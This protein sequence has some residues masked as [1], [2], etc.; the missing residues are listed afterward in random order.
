MDGASSAVSDHLDRQEVCRGI[1]DEKND[2]QTSQRDI[3]RLHV[4]ASMASMSFNRRTTQHERYRGGSIGVIPAVTIVSTHLARFEARQRSRK[5]PPKI[6][7][8]ITD[9]EASA[10]KLSRKGGQSHKMTKYCSAR[11]PFPSLTR[12]SAFS[13][14]NFCTWRRRAPKSL[15]LSA[16]LSRLFS[17]SDW[18]TRDR[19]TDSKWPV[20]SV[21]HDVGWLRCRFASVFGVSLLGRLDNRH[22]TDPSSRLFSLSCSK[23]SSHG[24]CRFAGTSSSSSGG[25]L[26]PFSEA[27]HFTIEDENAKEDW[28]WVLTFRAYTFIRR[29]RIGR[30]SNFDGLFGSIICG[31]WGEG[32]AAGKSGLCRANFE[33]SSF[34]TNF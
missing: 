17:D 4:F 12:G 11:M 8:S 29:R 19:R 34:L 3:K 31:R 28:W 33:F 10:K 32:G 7:S 1:L 6:A 27:R 2:A 21:T 26:Y 5:L 20:F 23:T 30:R 22:G 25:E 14:I 18:D 9:E 15:S 13:F 16:P 24:L